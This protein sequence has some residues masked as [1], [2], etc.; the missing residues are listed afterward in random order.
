MSQ[1]RN[2]APVKLELLLAVVHDEKAPYYIRLLQSYQSN[3]QFTTAAKGITHLILS[4]LGMT[5][6]PKTL[7]VSVVRADE[8]PKIIEELEE[9]F[10]KG[11]KYK[12]IAFTVELTS[13]IGTL[14]YGFLANDKRTV[15]EA[16]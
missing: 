2:I 6:T 5:E 10:Q 11:K 9:N 12:G 4:Y 13:V 3:L 1:T 8:V 15:K 16:R 14:V 7:L